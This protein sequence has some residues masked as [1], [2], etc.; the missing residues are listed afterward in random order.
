MR[1]LKY[2]LIKHYNR[3]KIKLNMV[4]RFLNTYVLTMGKE[5]SVTGVKGLL[6]VAAMLV[7]SLIIVS[8]V[9]GQVTLFSETFESYA[10]TNSLN[11]TGTNQWLQS[12][13]TGTNNYWAIG[14]NS[15][16]ITGNRSLTIYDNNAGTYYSYRKN[17]SC[18]RIAYY[19]NPI[20]ASNYTNLTLDFSWKCFGESGSPDYDYGMVVYSLDGSTW[21][22]VS[23][24][25]YL[26]Q[27]NKQSIVNLAI[28][29]AVNGKQ[30]YI[31]FR[32]INDNGFGS[33]PSFTI[34]DIIIQGISCAPAQPSAITGNIAPC[35]G[36][37][38]TYSITNVSGVTYNWTFPTGWVQTAGGTTNSV[39]V[40]VGSGSGN[41]TVTPSNVCGNGTA[42]TLGVTAQTSS[43]AAAGAITGL[44]TVTSGQS[45]VTY[46]VPAITR[47]GTYSWSYSGTGATINGTGNSIT[48]DFAS[49]ATSGNLTVYGINGC[50]N[51]TVSA[52][53]PITISSTSLCTV[54]P[55]SGLITTEAGGTATFTIKLNSAP[56]ASVTITFTSADASEG[57]VTSAALTFST[58]NWNT[59]RTVTI[60]GVDDAFIDGAVAYTIIGTVTS[61]DPK[62]NGIAVPEVSVTNTDNDAVAARSIQVDRKEPEGGY[63]ATDLVQNVMVKGCIKASN[64]T[65]NGISNTKNSQLGYFNKGTSDF[66]FSEGIVMST[67]NVSDAEGPN[68]VSNTSTSVGSDG[69]SDIDSIT[70]NNSYDAA[71]LEFDFIPAGDKV[72]F[73]YIFASEEYAEYIG[74]TYNDAFAFLISG[75]GITGTK[76]IALVPNTSTA[77]SI[78]NVHGPSYNTDYSQ[79]YVSNGYYSDWRGNYYRKYF[80]T[81]TSNATANAAYYVDNGPSGNDTIMNNGKIQAVNAGGLSTEFDGRTTVLTATQSVTACETYHIKLV[82]ADV[83]DAQ[84]N[85]GVF[86][87]AKSFT[88]NEIKME[89]LLLGSSDDKDVMYE[90]C[91][92]SYI[93]FVRASGSNINETVAFDVQI[94]GTATNGVDYKFVNSSGTVIDGGYGL[95]V[96]PSKATIPAGNEYVDY[97]YKAMSDGILEATET[98]IF[99]V[100]NSCPCDP[101]VTYFTKKVTIIDVPDIQ[102]TGSANVQCGSSGTPVVTITATLQSGMDPSN[103]LF[104]L[105]NSGIFQTS[106][107]FVG[108]W[109]TGTS[110]TVQVKDKFSCQSVT[111]APIII[112]AVSPIL[113]NAGADKEMCQF[114]SGIQLS[115][116]GGI[117]YEWSSV[118]ANGISYISNKYAAQPTIL[119]TIPVGTYT[120]T[121]LVQ[122]QSGSTPICKGTDDMVLTVK[123]T[124]VV[125]AIADKYEVC[126]GTLINLS[127]SVTNGVA[128]L[129]Y[130]WNPSGE[131]SDA[132]IANPFFTPVVSSL[133]SRSFTVTVKSANLCSNTGQVPNIAI[134]PS[135][136]ITVSSNT[137]AT[138]ADH[139]DGQIIITVSGGTPGSPTAYTYDWRNSSNINVGT[140]STVSNLL[141]GNYT[142]TVTDGKSCPSIKVITVGADQPTVIITPTAPVT[143]A[144]VGLAIIAT[145]AG[146]SGVYSTHAWTGAGAT[147]LS[148]TSIVNPTFTNATTGSYALTYTVTDS[149]GCRG[150]AS[151]TVTVNPKPAIT[152]MTSTVCSGTGFTVTPVNAT[153]GI[154]PTGTTYSWGAPTGTGFTGG[155][156]S[157]GSSSSITGTLTNTTSSTVTATYT[158]TPISG[159]CTG[160]T[161]TVSINITPIPTVTINYAGSPFCKSLLTGQT[162]TLTGTGAYT[163]GTYSSTTGLS[164]DA[165]TGAIIPGTSTA[166]IYTVTYT[167]P[168]SGGCGVVPT[169]T[170]VTITAKPTATISYTSTTFCKSLATGQTVT[171]TGTGAYTGGIYSSAAGLTIDAS[172]GAITPGGSS[173]GIYT[174]TYNTPVS[175]GC[176]AVPTTTSVTIASNPTA[177]IYPASPVTCE[178]LDIVLTAIPAGGSGSYPTH[179]W[180]GAG[181]VFLSATN[182]AVPNFKNLTAG[183]YALIYTVTDSNG[184]NG[185]ANTI[186][187]VD[188]VPATGPVYRQPNN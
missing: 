149:K 32:W 145:P 119:S 33:D 2:K 63:G 57:T 25:H 54:T 168:A 47:A 157:S 180:T 118:P 126:S 60:K 39:T 3:C 187:T 169:T 177:T 18:E 9:S 44:A 26:G 90:G 29:S 36:A 188:L 93:R 95:G 38:E 12:I 51:G 75:P 167:A 68:K 14:N 129:T 66:P 37:T 91:D 146:G 4:V 160:S 21:L 45:G 17:R 154:V 158:V 56:T 134:N 185:I 162:V 80:K 55:T 135:P 58:T 184:C 61:T 34:D 52:N 69:D 67:G 165:S 16:S 130:S 98:A 87:E 5:K 170:S 107:Q 22:D 144:G 153:N 124:P 1:G 183:T 23:T 117:Y 151:T 15:N 100:I 10:A 128:P 172:T 125:T 35:R 89:N 24:T 178:G 176:A 133:S 110:H 175:G 65:F 132:T 78:N 59:A 181:S 109:A 113:A 141:P 101:V 19:S 131:L 115:G 46:T 81:V 88:S 114:Q 140:T 74:A 71:V 127:T 73:N 85:S 174:V 6:R 122:D 104:G 171:L 27:S 92:N 43:P 143:C 123:P 77:V 164:I 186:V 42:R 30:F 156:A 76:N 96:F 155:A 62:F 28:P 8:K 102:T 72:Q 161:F 173:A 94:S 7:I 84:Y 182:I 99:Q 121:L 120:F 142:V 179:E 159:S 136:V 137:N 53:Y 166:G 150:T 79:V 152:V 97:Y 48:V 20:D 31:G 138:C 49:N 163:G 82:V 108:T 13:I 83:G 50:G 112:P 70:K 64:V 86:L 111:S 11:A 106:N 139:S 105:D 116:S 40:T 103:Y 147:S 148:S 41:I